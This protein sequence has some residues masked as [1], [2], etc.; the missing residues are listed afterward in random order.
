VE[1]AIRHAI[2]VAWSR[3]NLDALQ[4]YFGGIVSAEKGRPTNA[5]CIATLAEWVRLGEGARVF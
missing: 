3:G 4:R 5:E 1:R 2:E